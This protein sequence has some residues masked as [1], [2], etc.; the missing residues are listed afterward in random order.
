MNQGE[1]EDLHVYRIT[2]GEKYKCFIFVYKCIIYSI[3]VVIDSLKEKDF[4][5]SENRTFK[6]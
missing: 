1:G 3:V 5:N 4:L 6:N 2:Q